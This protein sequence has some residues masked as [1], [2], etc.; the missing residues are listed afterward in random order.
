MTKKYFLSLSLCLVIGSC[1]WSNKSIFTT[2]EQD[3]LVKSFTIDKDKFKKFAKDEDESLG[4][5]LDTEKK[6]I[7]VKE[8]TT[9]EKGKKTVKPEKKV[10]EKVVR[11][12][13]TVKKVKPIQDIEKAAKIKPIQ[14]KP[15]PKD[16]PELFKKYDKE[17]EKVWKMFKPRYIPNE[18]FVLD[19]KYLGITA[20]K[21]TVRTL[22][23]SSIGGKPV[24]HYLAK[25][26]S[27]PFYKW[28]YTLDDYV[29]TFVDPKTHLPIKYQLVQRE[30]KQDVDDLQLF[31]H[32]KMKSYFWYKRLKRG[33]TTKREKEAYIPRYVQDSF[34]VLYFVRGLPIEIGKKISFPVVTRTKVWILSFEP[35]KR[36]TIKIKNKEYKAIRIKAE[37][38]YPGV[39]K[40]RGDIHF[41]YSDDENKNLLKFAAKVKIGTV[42][43]D[44]VYYSRDGKLPNFE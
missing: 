40:K 37:T 13:K 34:A 43:G 24:F 36:E 42:E 5:P 17:S 44:L 23:M 2:N 3:D 21:V 8:I 4:E 1:A 12:T 31:D 16:Y 26:K 20:G 10:K 29:E 11:K 33:E 27:A 9:A 15:Y 32:D 41:W 38:H 35:E 7:V 22:P 39:L 14:F 28:F 30:S 19:V 25:I 6:E 18:L